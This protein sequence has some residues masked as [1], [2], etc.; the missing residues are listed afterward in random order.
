VGSWRS[1]PQRFVYAAKSGSGSRELA[2]VA[3]NRR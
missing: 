1:R 3:A 2:A